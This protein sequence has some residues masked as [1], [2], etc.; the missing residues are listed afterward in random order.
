MKVYFSV[1][2]KAKTD[3]GKVYK[4]IF[5]EISRLGYQHVSEEAIHE[6]EDTFYEEMEKGGKDTHQ[7]LFKQKTKFIQSADINVFDLSAGGVGL[8]F[9]VEKSLELNKPTIVVYH[10]DNVPFF[11]SGI[12]DDKFI[13]V[14]YTEKNAKKIIKESL[15]VARER[16]DKRFNFF[17]SPRLLD[18][19]E[20]AS[21]TEGVTKSKF[22]RN[23]IV[24]KMRDSSTKVQE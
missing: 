13:L 1:S 6:D 23:L 11:L 9:N 12:D 15:E 20:K 17:I 18:Y 8:G 10:G 14:G 21:G 5:D 24:K 4:I 3:L 7:N 2:P 19:L 16:R 22:I